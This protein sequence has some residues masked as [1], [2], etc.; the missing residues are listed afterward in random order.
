MRSGLVFGIAI[1]SVIC[2]VACG[3][4]SSTAAPVNSVAQQSG[5]PAEKS[6]D[7]SAHSDCLV[8]QEQLPL[9]IYTAAREDALDPAGREYFADYDDHAEPVWRLEHFKV[10]DS[11]FITGTLTAGSAHLPAFDDGKQRFYRKSQ[12][13]CQ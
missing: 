10:V 8:N 9:K 7:S 4:G 5:A 11:T 1:G 6:L 2:S 12:W 3:G 13:V